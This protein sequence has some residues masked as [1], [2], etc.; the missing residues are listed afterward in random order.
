MKDRKTV[1]RFFTI[2]YYIE[3]ESWLREQS[4][5][6]WKLVGNRPPCF[7][8]FEKQEPEDVIY[9][10]DYRNG[11]ENSEYR[12]IFHDFGWEQ[13]GKCAGWIYY[14]KPVSAVEND[15]EGEIFS[16]VE[17]R[18]DMIKHIY[19]TRMLPICII[20]LCCLIPQWT[21]VME[22]SG[23]MFLKVFFSVLLVLYIAL[24]GH[25]G[26]KLGKIKRTLR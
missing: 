20:F 23:E 22:R 13:C 19:K 12:Q 21:S 2:A 24:I 25:C 11:K 3:E 4:K 26:L 15:N 7:F 5:N 10:L 8:T 17:T 1:I 16:D 9:K 18:Y 14:R 6:G